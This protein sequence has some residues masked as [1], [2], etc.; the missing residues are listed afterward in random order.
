M[1]VVGD[2]SMIPGWEKAVRSMSIGERAVVRITDP[3][4]GYGASGVPPLVPANAELE[5]DIEILDA[6]PPM[7]N[8]DFDSLA[9]ADST[10][11]RIFA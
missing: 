11:V 8:I 6:Q 1:Q 4:L 7:A 2:G 9:T 10:P 3:E 5:F